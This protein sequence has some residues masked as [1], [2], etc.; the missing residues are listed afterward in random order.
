M[1]AEPAD[2]FEA[3]RSVADLQRAYES[4]MNGITWA[5]TQEGH[6]YW[7][8]VRERLARIIHNRK[9]GSDVSKHVQASPTVPYRNTGPKASKQ[10]TQQQQQVAGGKPDYMNITRNMVG[11]K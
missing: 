3:C 10:A 4:I 6:D 7:K 9:L 8:D 11:Q 5:K 1:A 2:D